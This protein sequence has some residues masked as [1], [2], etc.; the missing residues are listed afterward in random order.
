MNLGQLKIFYVAGKMGSLS[1]AAEELYVTQPAV[2]KGIQ[3]L[4]DHYEI[5]L[6]NRFG[7]KMVLTDAGEALFEIAEKIF[8]LETQ[9]EDTIRDFLQQKSAHIRINSSETFGAYYLPSIINPISKK[10]P[11]IR[12][13]INILPSYLVVEQVAALNNDVGFISY[14][15]ENEKVTCRAILEDHMI[16]VAP[17]DHPLANKKQLTHRDLLGHPMIVHEKGSYSHEITIDF[18]NKHNLEILITLE[19][20][21]NKAMKKAVEDGLGIAIVSRYTALRHLHMKKLVELSFPGPP[22]TRRYYMVHHKDK[23]FSKTLSKLTSKVDEWAA[24]YHDSL[25]IVHLRQQ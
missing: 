11:N 20:S 19:L 15:I 14:P 10:Y 2:T 8:E 25:G 22:I 9:A 17:P 5:K 23:Y 6:F 1:K 24:Q 16:F 3:K 13:S 7:K 4:Q 21:S 12:F 18:F